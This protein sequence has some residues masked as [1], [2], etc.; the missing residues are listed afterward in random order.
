ML[1][2]EARKRDSR[3]LLEESKNNSQCLDSRN[4]NKLINAEN[5]NELLEGFESEN[6]ITSKTE[7]RE[8]SPRKRLESHNKSLDSKEDL[9]LLKTTPKNQDLLN[10]PIQKFLR[11]EKQNKAM[12]SKTTVKQDKY[13]KPFKKKNKVD[14]KRFPFNFD[15]ET[16]THTH[17]TLSA[18][19]INKNRSSCFE[20]TGRQGGLYFCLALADASLRER[21]RL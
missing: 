4:T 18:Y 21:G 10:S 16:K 12:A 11:Q 15:A 8:M 3:K 7:V 1:G 20:R 14:K 6:Y 13:R 9:V 17:N 2:S 19:S 5:L